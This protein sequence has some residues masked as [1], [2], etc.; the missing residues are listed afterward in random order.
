MMYNGWLC[1]E[2]LEQRV[3]LTL[4]GTA[5]VTFKVTSCSNYCQAYRILQLLSNLQAIPVTVKPKSCSSY[6]QTYGLF[7]LLSN[8]KAAPV[9]VKTTGCSSYC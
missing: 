8:L 9:T 6:C 4:T 7:Q 3:G 5:T 1:A 2:E